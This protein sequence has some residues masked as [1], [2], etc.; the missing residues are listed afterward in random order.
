MQNRLG[1]VFEKSTATPVLRLGCVH[2]I[3]VLCTST[4]LYSRV[5]YSCCWPNDGHPLMVT[6]A[7]KNWLSSRFGV[8]PVWMHVVMRLC[9]ID[10]SALAAYAAARPVRAMLLRIP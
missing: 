3:R 8:K 9:R 1:S 7:L 10:E 6:L 4:Q 2:Y 5:S